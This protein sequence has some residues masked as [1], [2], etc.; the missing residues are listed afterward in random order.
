M[1]ELIGKE[2]YVSYFNFSPTAHWVV[3]EG[4]DMP[5]VKIRDKWL[6]YPIWINSTLI[7]TISE[8]TKET[9]A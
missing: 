7:R 2:C 1:K 9:E 6:D 5:M 8:S 4:V 3:V